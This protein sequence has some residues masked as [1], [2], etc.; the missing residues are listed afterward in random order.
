LTLY[1]YGCCIG[2][3]P[4]ILYAGVPY[5]LLSGLTTITVLG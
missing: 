2:E 4:S 5:Y 1:M 3:M